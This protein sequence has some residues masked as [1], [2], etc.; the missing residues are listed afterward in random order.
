M[1]KFTVLLILC[2]ALIITALNSF[3]RSITDLVPKENIDRYKNITS[4]KMTGT[5]EMAGLKGT[6]EELYLAPDKVKLTID[7]GVL[8]ISQGYDG[9]TAW[10]LDQNGQ[11][12]ELTG[13]EKKQII[14]TVYMTSASYLMGDRLP[15]EVVYLKDTSIEEQ[16]YAAFMIY[17]EA[18]DSLQAFFNLQTKRFEITVQW[19]EGIKAVIYNSDFR[20]VGGLEM[21]FKAVTVASLPQLNGVMEFTDLEANVD[22]DPAI[23]MM[24]GEDAADFFFPDQDSVIVG[25]E[26]VGGHIYLNVYLNDVKRRL[27]LDSGAGTNVVDKTVADSLG[28][29]CAGDLPSKGVTGYGTASVSKIDSLA[30]GGVVLYDQVCGVVD[31]ADFR[32]KLPG[33]LAGI[34]GYDF[35]SRFPFKVDYENF[36]LTLYHPERFIP[37]DFVAPIPFEYYMKI[38]TVK[39]SYHNV[40][41]LFVVDLGNPMSLML[42]R[43]YVEKYGLD[44][45]F[46]DI[47]EMPGGIGGIGGGSKAVAAVGDEFV[48]GADTVRNLPVLVVQSDQGLA[49]SANVAGNI[50]NLLLKKFILVGDYANR[51]LYLLPGE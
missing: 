33:G 39:A 4:L 18:G 14:N 15:G 41:G 24:G 29:E 28:F 3:G 2:L 9:R 7:F 21:A 10:L 40:E 5:V 12:V 22:I 23:F 31:L 35:L 1:N 49:E 20:E 44:S 13:T 6:V 38:P 36:E 47:S 25:F 43:P 51:R 46:K 42:H 16:T 11:Y 32:L 34:L 19:Q 27:I 17:P 8:R 30:V 45:T 48:I 50:G 26:F 37:P